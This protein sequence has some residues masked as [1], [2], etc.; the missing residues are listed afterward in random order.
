MPEQK[1]MI[2]CKAPIPGQVKTRLIR[3]LGADGA[4]QVHSE[5]ASRMLQDCLKPKVVGSAMLELWCS[6]DTKDEFYDQFPIERHLQEGED[7]GQRMAFAFERAGVPAVL[8]GTDCPRLDAD[9]LQRALAKLKSHDAVLG[10]AEDGGYGLIGLQHPNAD[11]FRSI[12][13]GTASVCSETC[14]VMNQKKLNWS[15]LP[16]LWDVDRPED[17]K[18]Y[19]NLKSPLSS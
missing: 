16:L 19:K 11:L 4:A 15:L 10:P 12:K 8:I 18:R 2:F 6:P 1:I 5:L 14:R 9:Y 17:V 3:D 13:W 7:L